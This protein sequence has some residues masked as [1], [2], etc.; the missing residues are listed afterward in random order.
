M[1]D[2]RAFETYLVQRVREALAR[3]E[4]ELGVSVVVT[5]GA[6]SLSGVVQSAERRARIESLCRA[7]C[8]GYALANRIEVRPPVAPEAAER[9][10]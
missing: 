9:L 10:A 7:L 2:L 6:V 5:P 8:E 1:S 4:G 3:E